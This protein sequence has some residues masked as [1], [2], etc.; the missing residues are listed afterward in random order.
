MRFS[1]HFKKL[2]F[3][4][5]PMQQEQQCTPDMPVSFLKKKRQGHSVKFG[6]YN[7]NHEICIKIINNPGA[8]ITLLFSFLN[9]A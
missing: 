7:K 6:W 8:I 9:L 4:Q 3:L 2:A 1:Q 5:Q